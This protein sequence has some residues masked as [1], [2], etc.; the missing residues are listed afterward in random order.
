MTV[1]KVTKKINRQL[2]KK[3]QRR[4]LFSEYAKTV[5]FIFTSKIILL[6]LLR[7]SL[8]QII[9]YQRQGKTKK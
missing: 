3:A 7:L 6:T 2:N 9:H 5:L 1:E 8:M 4:T